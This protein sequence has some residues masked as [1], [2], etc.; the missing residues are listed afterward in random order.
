VTAKDIYVLKYL[1]R[2]G[3]PRLDRNNAKALI[4]Q[5]LRTAVTL[6]LVR[7]VVFGTA[8]ENADSRNAVA[9]VIVEL[10]GNAESGR[11]LRMIGKHLIIH[12]AINDLLVAF[13]AS[14]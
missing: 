13:S 1:A 5:F 14:R 7:I 6:G 11:M 12:D 10:S 3:R 2:N 9:F 4:A 8:D